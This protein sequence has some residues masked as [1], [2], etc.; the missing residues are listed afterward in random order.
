MGQ[1]FFNY[2]RILPGEIIPKGFKRNGEIND[3]DINK[4]I[5]L[6]Q[7]YSRPLLYVGGG[8]IYSGAHEEVETLANNYQIA[9][10]T[11]NGTESI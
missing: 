9:V 3:S 5:E 8:A 4:A 10:T 1:E 11:T 7:E 6:I 2:E